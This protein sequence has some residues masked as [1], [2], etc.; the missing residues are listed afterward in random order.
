LFGQFTPDFHQQG[1]ETGVFVAQFAIEIPDRSIHGLRNG[2]FR[3]GALT[4][5]I[6]NGGLDPVDNVIAR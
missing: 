6:E 5:T 3:G 2:G 1:F 4:E